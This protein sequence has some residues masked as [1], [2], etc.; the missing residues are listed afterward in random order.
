M[1]GAFGLGLAWLAAT[2]SGAPV[3]AAFSRA[4]RWGDAIRA[5]RW[6]EWFVG[7][8]AVASRLALL[9]YAGRV[10]EALKVGEE[11]RARRM[12][13]YDR[14]VWVN[15]L[16]TGGRYESA[17]E[18]G[19]STDVTPAGRALLEVNLAEAEYNLGN[20]SEAL[21][22]LDAV[23]A[24]PEK[25]DPLTKAG[26][27]LQ[28]AWI[29]AHLGDAATARQC[30]VDAELA[31]LPE[32]FRAEYH[33]T[34]AAVSIAEGA[35]DEALAAVERGLDLAVRVPSRRNGLF[36]RARIRVARGEPDLALV[37]F[38]AGA[39]VNYRGQ[40]GDGLL[41]WGDLLQSLGR[42]GTANTAWRLTVERDPESESAR[43][44]FTRLGSIRQHSTEE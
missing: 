11:L 34:D 14:I 22:R 36:L 40:G 10:S 24:L 2:R 26:E 30:V 25:L 4:G 17:L 12:R 32:I 19:R 44:A 8:F 18:V 28:R 5:T 27:S 21:R 29:L 7:D 37:D 38:E 1:W 43:L 33:F 39:A 15:A 42:M 6:W 3:I 20:W 13:P 41:A 9:G 16:I 31:A 35:L 23:R